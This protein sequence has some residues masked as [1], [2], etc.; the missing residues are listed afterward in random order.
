MSD[1]RATDTVAERTSGPRGHVASHLCGEFLELGTVGY[2][3]IRNAV[4]HPSA[5][6]DG[7]ER[8]LRACYDKY[9]V[10]DR[11]L[12]QQYGAGQ[13]ESVWA[14]RIATLAVWRRLYETDDLISSWDGLSVV[15]AREQTRCAAALNVHGEPDWIH[16]D[17]R[18]SNESLADTIQGYLALSDADASEYSTIFYA[19]KCGT[20]QQLID[21]Y[22][23]EFCWAT[24]RYGRSIRKIVNDDVDH[25][26]FSE[27]ELRWFRERCELHKPCLRA[28]DLLLWCS[29]MPH[30]AAPS[31][32]CGNDARPRLG[33]F[34]AMLPKRFA[35]A[36]ILSTRREMARTGLTSSHNVLSPVLFPFSMRNETKNCD[37]SYSQS[38][39][40]TRRRLIG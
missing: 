9:A 15:D 1:A 4:E 10:P 34:V 31:R 5:L 16:R 8:D 27:S 32:A 23:A 25:H 28:G 20:A 7:I 11:R 12:L 21:E 37:T 26:T 19:P 33:T 35:N 40:F 17:Q 3:V 6:R 14:A 29:A 36:L 2:Q 38:V 39:A 24:N 18:L 30:A 13:W 22:H